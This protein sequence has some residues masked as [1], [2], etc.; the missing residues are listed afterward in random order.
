MPET[1]T[2]D[3]DLIVRGSVCTM[4]ATRPAAEAFAVRD[5]KVAAVG[6]EADVMAL[7]GPRTWV[8]NSGDG[9]VMPGIVDIHSHVG[10]GGQAAAWE[11][12]LPPAYGPY[13]ILAAVTDWADGLGPDNRQAV[14]GHVSGLHR[15]GPR[16]LHRPRGPDPCRPGKGDL[17]RRAPRSQRDRRK[18]PV[19]TG[20]R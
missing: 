4:D 3:A 16:P 8:T 18:A 14:A 10:F 5:G 20:Q 13:D 11:L 9:M 1:F 15:P 2:G 7:A 6:D 12:R 17:V 19:V